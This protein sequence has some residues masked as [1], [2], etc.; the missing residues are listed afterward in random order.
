MKYT[1]YLINGNHLNYEQ[2]MP[3]NDIGKGIWTMVVISFSI[4]MLGFCMI[5]L[6]AT[7]VTDIGR[8]V[9]CL[10]LKM[11]RRFNRYIAHQMERRKLSLIFV[12]IPFRLL[13]VARFR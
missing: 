9:Y 1:G 10:K 3:K 7:I 2:F 4:F 13:Q 12:Q 6:P 11:S 8:S 5:L